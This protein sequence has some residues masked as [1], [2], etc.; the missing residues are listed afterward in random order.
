MNLQ[1]TIQNLFAVTAR[2]EKALGL[3][4]FLEKMK[5]QDKLMSEMETLAKQEKTLLG[6]IIRFPMADS[7]AVYVITKVNKRTVRILWLDYCDGWIDPRCGKEANLNLEFATST[8]N[9]RD[10]LDKLFSK[11]EI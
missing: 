10:A 3:P 8:V 11:K 7:Y 5:L 2:S 4:S 6:R 1:D 9:G